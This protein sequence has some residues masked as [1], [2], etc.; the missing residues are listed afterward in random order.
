[1]VLASY[2]VPF[3]KLFTTLSPATSPQNNSGLSL[4]QQS[5][6]GKLLRAVLWEMNGASLGQAGQWQG[7]P[8]PSDPCR[9]QQI[10]RPVG[11]SP[12][13]WEKLEAN[14]LKAAL[15]LKEIPNAQDL[16]PNKNMEFSVSRPS[17]DV[18]S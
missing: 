18:S 15:A 7:R 1:M 2:K 9:E 13:S 12:E 6:G 14:N 3:T 4:Q 17:S 10:R 8:V 11:K 16:A 5:L